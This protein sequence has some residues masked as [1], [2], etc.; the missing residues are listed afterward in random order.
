MPSRSQSLS[1]V[2]VVPGKGQN[3]R[4]SWVVGSLGLKAVPRLRLE[5]EQPAVAAGDRCQE[6]SRSWVQPE[7]CRQEAGLLGPRGQVCFPDRP[8]GRS[9]VRLTK[10][11]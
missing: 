9:R 4:L 3:P 10:V 7:V 11:T 8:Y 5:D 1:T 2:M 6:Q